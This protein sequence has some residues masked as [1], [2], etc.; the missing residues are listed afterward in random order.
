MVVD[1]DYFCTVSIITGGKENLIRKL[2][3]IY[4]YFSVST[5]AA[6]YTIANSKTKLSFATL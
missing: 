1:R 6:F 3:P 2:H 4:I 5:V